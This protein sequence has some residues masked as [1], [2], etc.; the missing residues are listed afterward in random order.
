MSSPARGGSRPEAGAAGTPKRASGVPATPTGAAGTLVLIGGALDE[1]AE[2]LDRIVALASAARI[3]DGAPRIA[4]LTTASEPAA[5]AASAASDT[6]ESDEADG[7]YYAELFARHGA[8]G[9]PIPVGV[10]PRPPFPG[11][12]YHRG[13]AESEAFAELV[14]SCD[15]VFLGGGD[16]T[17]Y[18]LALFRAEDA[19]HSHLEAVTGLDPAARRRDTPVMR[20]IRQVLERGGVVA[21]TSAGLAVQQGAG[22]V[23]GG[24]SREAWLRQVEPGYADDDAL[25]YLP[26]GG[27]GLFPEGLLDSHFTEWDRVARA[28]R[29]AG[30]LGRP[31][32]IGVDEHTALVY[33]R[34]ERSGEVIGSAGVSLLD[35]S[36][37]EFAGGEPDAAGPAWPAVHGA[38]WSH[39]T[40]GDRHD[41]A[42]GRTERATPPRTERGAEPGPPPARGL[43]GEDRGPAL[44]ALAQRLV[45]SRAD[46]AEGTTI[47][48]DGTAAP[49]AF[50]LTLQ[51]D[52]LTT[53]TDAGGFS[54][55]RLSIAPHQP[56]G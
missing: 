40:A 12:A 6:E 53:W 47:G 37:A 17:H 56:N 16:Q 24:T 33:R 31:L 28:V 3:E 48:A 49:P 35:V 54:D 11:A 51:R 20:A 4:I 19:A 50:A 34:S 26:A 44:L 27:L 1:N 29:L 42:T 55:L 14:R 15:G 30:A 13:T 25:R 9:V 5:S 38:R 32:A 23:S 7:R 46:V 36:A 39:L 8:V 43:W 22:M 18:V 52:E 21:G 45:A 41:F 2:I 10:S